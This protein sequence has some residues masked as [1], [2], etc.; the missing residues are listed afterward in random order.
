VN[1]DASI[2]VN[3]LSADLVQRPELR[4]F[5]HRCKHMPLWCRA[6]GAKGVFS[7]RAHDKG[8]SEAPPGTIVNRAH[9]HWCR[10]RA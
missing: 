10:A 4:R 7:P 5:E 3:V 1:T 8:A 9:A 2:S 6:G